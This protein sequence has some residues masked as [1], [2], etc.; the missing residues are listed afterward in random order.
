MYLY[1]PS[2]WADGLALGQ[3]RSGGTVEL[4]VR[5]SASQ[6]MGALRL[7]DEAGLDVTYGMVF[8]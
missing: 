6:P 1:F 3:Y 7:H 8:G 5:K 2:T 4:L